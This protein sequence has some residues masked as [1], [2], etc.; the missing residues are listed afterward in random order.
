V[1]PEG[2]RLPYFIFGD[3][4][5]PVD[6][7]FADL[8]KKQPQRF[9]GRGSR[10]LTPGD[11]DGLEMSAS[12]EAGV[13]SVIFKRKRRPEETIAIEAA[14]WYPIAFSVWD[15]LSADR[16]NKRA[17][18]RWYYVYIEPA[19][20]VRPIVPMT[21]AALATLGIEIVLIAF[22]RRRYRNNPST[23]GTDT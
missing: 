13:W 2:I 8:A 1:L 11:P 19:A 18:T 6:V 17:L 23:P 10:S 15:G 12:Y 14:Q 22:I 4:D 5:N 21:K 20:T 3:S 16:G 7:W 9:V